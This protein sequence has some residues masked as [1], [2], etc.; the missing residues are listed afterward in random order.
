MCEIMHDFQD[1]ITA[2]KP[3]EH[4][5]FQS[6]CM[7]VTIRFVMLMQDPNQKVAMFESSDIIRYLEE[8]YAT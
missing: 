1:V 4:A 2:G 7:L 6:S 8:T 3:C 5:S